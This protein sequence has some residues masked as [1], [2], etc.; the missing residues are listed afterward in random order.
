[1]DN[2]KIIILGATGIIGETLALSLSEMNFEL[3]LISRDMIKLK[4]LNDKIKSKYNLNQ[5]IFEF[6]LENDHQD[7]LINFLK[8]SVKNIKAFIFLSR[9]TKYLIDD[10]KGVDIDSFRKEFD[11]SL[12]YPI[13]LSMQ[14]H[15]VYKEKLSSIIFTSSIY[16]IS[17]P[18]EELYDKEG[19]TPISY[20][21]SR[22]SII[23]AAKHLS[24]KMAGITNVNTVVLGGIEHNQNK[25]F[26]EK[27][28]F[29][30]PSNKMISK[31]DL[32]YPYL[33]FINAPSTN[34]TGSVL[35]LDGGWTL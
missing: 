23:Q 19:F 2:N 14:L 32:I 20:T 33:Y 34:F 30:C 6:D 35:V 28:S 5:E 15:R 21:S 4:F 10:K 24:K 17:I 22:A 13:S 1:M 25:S 16:G 31:K 12:F 27:Y 3:I 8:K 18:K 9:N 26:I 7:I 29:L 11:I